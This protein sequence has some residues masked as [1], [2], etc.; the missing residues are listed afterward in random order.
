M[1]QG[2]PCC[3]VALVDTNVDDN[4][5]EA[6]KRRC[7]ASGDSQTEPMTGFVSP[8]LFVRADS[9]LENEI[10]A[11]TESSSSAARREITRPGRRSRSASETADGDLEWLLLSLSVV[12]YSQYFSAIGT[13]ISSMFTRFT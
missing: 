8:L 10:V 13:C 4:N 9:E 11:L 2:G 6:I 12:I 3:H 7:E 1:T 5:A